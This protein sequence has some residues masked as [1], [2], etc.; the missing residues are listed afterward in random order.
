MST[1]KDQSGCSEKFSGTAGTTST[2]N[3]ERI[4]AAPTMP[5]TGSLAH[6]HQQLHSNDKSSH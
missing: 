5:N 2:E 4:G 1:N 6:S 3:F